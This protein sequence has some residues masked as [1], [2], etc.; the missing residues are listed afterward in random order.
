MA[1]LLGY[2]KFSVYP[3]VFL[4]VALRELLV[5]LPLCV[6]VTLLYTAI[7]RRTHENDS[8]RPV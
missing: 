1:N 4:S 8:R 2:Y 7:Y 3:E 6:P 5:T